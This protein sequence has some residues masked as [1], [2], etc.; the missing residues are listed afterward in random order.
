MWQIIGSFMS[1]L[2]NKKLLIQQMLPTFSRLDPT[3]SISLLMQTHA[4]DD[5]SAIQQ[6]TSSDPALE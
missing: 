5:S 3:I 2:K 6:Q 1:N 4:C